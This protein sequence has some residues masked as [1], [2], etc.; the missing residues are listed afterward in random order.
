MRLTFGIDGGGEILGRCV[1]P[2]SSAS[3][4]L[5]TV[6]SRPRTNSTLAGIWTSETILFLERESDL[7]SVEESSRESLSKTSEMMNCG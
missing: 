7:S 5:E 1:D 3:E 6:E 4:N 2:L